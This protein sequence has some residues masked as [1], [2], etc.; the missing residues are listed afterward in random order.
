M[1][2]VVLISRPVALEANDEILHKLKAIAR[3]VVRRL[4]DKRPLSKH[5][6]AR[7]A[8][9]VITMVDDRVDEAFLAAMPN[10]KVIANHAVGYNNIDIAAA[11]TRG[12]VVCNTPDVLTNATA[13][14]TIALLLAGARR[15]KEGTEELRTN[16]YKGWHPRHLLGAELAGSRLG[17]VGYGR[18]GRSVAKKARALGMDVVFHSPGTQGSLALSKLLASSDFVSI[19]CPLKSETRNLISTPEFKKMKPGAYLIN[20]ARGEIVDENALIKALSGKL[21]GAALDVFWNEPKLNPKL[22]RLPNAF[23][24]PHL[25]SAT[26]QAR[27]GMA[28]LAASGVIEVLTGRSPR[29]RVA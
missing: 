22:A 2:P 12:V 9:G 25:G 1:K 11:K 21:R 7:H 6:Q 15:F 29:N 23:I 3:V 26:V 19:H 28:R 27:A 5:R 14:L 8:V 24:V 18:I 13:E 20:T 16:R 10:L 17:I 4:G